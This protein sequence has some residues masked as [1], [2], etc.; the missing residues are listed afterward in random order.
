MK[1]ALD[2][3]G[4]LYDRVKA[5]IT[6]LA[7]IENARGWLATMDK[8]IYCLDL[9]DMSVNNAAAD[10]IVNM[11]EDEFERLLADAYWRKIHNT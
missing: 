5:R 7:T 8:Y 2:T 3:L 1:E 6:P 11:L 10:Y 9:L 4:G